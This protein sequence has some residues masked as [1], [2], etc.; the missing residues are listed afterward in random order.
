MEKS[1]QRELN[2]IAHG[3][4]DGSGSAEVQE[5]IQSHSVCRFVFFWVVLSGD[6]EN[7]RKTTLGMFI[8]SDLGC[9]AEQTKKAY[10]CLLSWKQWPVL[11]THPHT[12]L[13]LY[14]LQSSIWILAANKWQAILSVKKN[15]PLVV[16]TE[17]PLCNIN[18]IKR[19]VTVSL[20]PCCTQKPCFSSKMTLEHESV[21]ILRKQHEKLFIS[22]YKYTPASTTYSVDI[23]V[24][25]SAWTAHKPKARLNWNL[26]I[27]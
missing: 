5:F 25:N 8:T 20:S 13:F 11:L 22:W 23:K 12:I 26:N 9:R 6:E 18:W 14:E 1:S 2:S 17:E 16:L 15:C 21:R 3:R 27:S 10:L 24:R 19:N 4:W 7:Q